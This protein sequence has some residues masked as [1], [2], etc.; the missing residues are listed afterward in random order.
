MS[1]I[2]N[3]QPARTKPEHAFAPEDEFCGYLA[4]RHHMDSHDYGA[5]GEQDAVP[6]RARAIGGP[7]VPCTE[8]PGGVCV[9]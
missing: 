4:C 1:E 3:W 8:C 9:R 7:D 6:Y 5:P 2:D